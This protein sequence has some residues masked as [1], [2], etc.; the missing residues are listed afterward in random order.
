MLKAQNA[1]SSEIVSQLKD[2]EGSSRSLVISLEKQLS[3]TKESVSTLSQQN[4]ALQQKI[5]EGNIT[6]EG[7][8]SEVAGLKKLMVEKDNSAQVAAS[9]KRHAEVELEQTKVRLDDTK[10]ALDSMKRK[11]QDKSGGDGS[12]D[13]RHLAICPVCNSNIRNTTLKTCGHVFCND[14][15]QNLVKN[16]NRKCPACG[17]AFGNGDH[18][19]IHL[20]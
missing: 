4:R 12:D 16:R 3:E 6:L 5:N 20:A 10:K 2:S 7:L 17:K 14:C 18:M 9:T 1:R 15:V 19:P 13:W 8:R 11:A